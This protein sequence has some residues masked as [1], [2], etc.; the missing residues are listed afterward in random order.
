MTTHVEYLMGGGVPIPRANH[1]CRAVQKCTAEPEYSGKL[2]GVDCKFCR[3]YITARPSLWN[4]L[5]AA[6][7]EAGTA[8]PLGSV[9]SSQLAERQAAI[10]RAAEAK[11]K[12]AARKRDG[13]AA[14]R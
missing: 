4:R 9:V 8:T 1:P 12:R 10:V 7:L 3:R 6:D 14:R 11:E 2:S 13:K 5:R